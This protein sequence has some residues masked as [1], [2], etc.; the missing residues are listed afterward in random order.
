MVGRDFLRN[1]LFQD[2]ATLEHHEPWGYSHVWAYTQTLVFTSFIFQWNH[3][4]SKT[5]ECYFTSLKVKIAYVELIF[6]GVGRSYLRRCENSDTSAYNH[7]NV[8]VILH[9]HLHPHFEYF[10]IRNRTRKVKNPGIC[11]HLSYNQ[12]LATWVY[13]M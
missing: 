1:D 8:N 3:N 11:G 2:L 6:V 13:R 12:V 4:R 5:L 7:A 10:H 9:P